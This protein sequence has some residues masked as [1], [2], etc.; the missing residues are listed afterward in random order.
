MNYIAVSNILKA[1]SKSYAGDVNQT[2]GLADDY[3]SLVIE[4]AQKEVET[5][6]L[7]VDGCL[8][9]QTLTLSLWPVPLTIIYKVQ[10]VVFPCIPPNICKHPIML[11]LL[12]H[13]QSAFNPLT[14]NTAFFISSPPFPTH[15]HISYWVLQSLHS[16]PINRCLGTGH[17]YPTHFRR[18]D[19]QVVE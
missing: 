2:S 1:E 5:S 3:L 8:T 10:M 14:L 13:S 6:W 15:H 17:H 4:L 16:K 7:G 12:L 9:G 19:I 18:L 11:Q